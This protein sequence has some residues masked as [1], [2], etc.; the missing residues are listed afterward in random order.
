MADSPDDQGFQKNAEAF[1]Y[2]SPCPT[3]ADLDDSQLPPV[4]TLSLD[5]E[6]RVSSAA[7]RAL[8]PMAS[9]SFHDP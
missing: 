2:R 5:L 1:C 6:D 8:G 9:L 4:C 7:I 3:Q